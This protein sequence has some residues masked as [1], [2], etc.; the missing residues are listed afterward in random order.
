M[1][2]IPERKKN[3]V[4]VAVQ[5][6]IIFHETVKTKA[7]AKSVTRLT[8]LLFILTTQKETSLHRALKSARLLINRVVVIAQ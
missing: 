7:H 5:V 3:C 1:F 2:E 4:L 8:L 6:R